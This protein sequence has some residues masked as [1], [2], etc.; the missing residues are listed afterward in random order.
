VRTSTRPA[1][2]L[3]GAQGADSSCKDLADDPPDHAL[4]RSRGAWTTSGRCKFPDTVT[5]SKRTGK[6]AAD[7]RPPAFD[8]QTFGTKHRRTWLYPAHHWRGVATGLDKYALTYLGKATLAALVT[9]HLVR[10]TQTQPRR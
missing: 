8:A 7:G 5:R 6:G 9:Y 4:G 10:I 3:C 2:R 1:H